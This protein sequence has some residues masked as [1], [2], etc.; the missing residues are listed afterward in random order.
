[1]AGFRIS[2]EPWR[3]MFWTPLSSFA[4]ETD[5]RAVT[6]FLESLTGE[7]PSRWMKKPELPPDGPASSRSPPE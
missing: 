5:A 1:M 2:A 7:L 4:S 3:F 6:V